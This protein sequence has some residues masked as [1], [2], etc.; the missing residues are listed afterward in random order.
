MERVQIHKGDETGDKGASTS[1][2]NYS[3]RKSCPRAPR[4]VHGPQLWFEVAYSH[5]GEWQQDGWWRIVSECRLWR[6]CGTC[7]VNK[8]G[9][10]WCRGRY[11]DLVWSC[12]CRPWMVVMMLWAASLAQAPMTRILRIA[13]PGAGP[14]ELHSR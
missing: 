10:S 3:T 6:R 5:D 9:Q 2:N 7:S 12:A 4:E 11:S 14:N 8:A 1:Y 13:N